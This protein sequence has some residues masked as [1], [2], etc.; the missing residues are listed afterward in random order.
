MNIEN[1]AGMELPQK[2]IL[3]LGGHQNMTKKLRQHF[4]KWTYVTDDRIRR[5][6]RISQTVVF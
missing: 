1:I 5:C 4:P 2:G 3:F 6:T